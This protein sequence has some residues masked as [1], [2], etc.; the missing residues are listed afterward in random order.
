MTQADLAGSEITRNMLSQ[1]ENDVAQPSMNTI[2]YI[3]A[4]LNVSPGFL[5]AEGN[6]EQIYLKYHEITDIKKAFMNEDYRI[7]RDMCLRSESGNDDEIK[8]ILADC[9][10]EIAAEE[11]GGG[12]LRAVCVFFDE[13]MEACAATIYRT[14]FVVAKAG[15]YFRYMQCISAT[16]SSDV[17]DEE[18]INIY[19]ALT[20][21]FCRYLYCFCSEEEGGASLAPT[22]TLDTLFSEDGR[23]YRLHLT[24]RRAIREGRYQDAYNDLHDILNGTQFLPEP[25][26]YF[27][28]C[29]MEICCRELQNFRGAYEYSNN[30]LALLQT[31]LT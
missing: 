8:M 6:D 7:C 19:P 18:K 26:L 13:A 16:L 5:L 4:R 12:N 3:A 21:E 24:A 30:K 10:M 2:R 27:V 31:L 17:A 22:E 11:F 25:M 9:D 29:D 20:D 28:F 1:I 15:L 14:D 23:A